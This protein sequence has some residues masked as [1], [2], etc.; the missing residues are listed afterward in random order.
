MALLNFLFFLC[1]IFQLWL[2]FGTAETE[3][4]TQFCFLEWIYSSS[5]F[6]AYLPLGAPADLA[7]FAAYT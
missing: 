5:S 2:L 6:E 1:R 7:T 4:G 3:G